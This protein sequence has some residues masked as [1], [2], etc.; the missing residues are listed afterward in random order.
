MQKKTQ[1]GLYLITPPSLKIEKFAASFEQALLADE[2]KIIAALQ[3]RLK[4]YTQAQLIS[5]ANALRPICV[6]HKIM[7]LM[8]DFPELASKTKCNGVHIGQ[9]DASLEVARASV[10]TSQIIGVTCHNSLKLARAASEKGADYVAFGAFFPTKTKA[11]NFLAQKHLLHEWAS[12][13]DIPSVAIGGITPENCHSLVRAGANF[14][15]VISSFWGHPN[16]P[17]AA[18]IA[19]KN[20]ITAA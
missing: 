18:V 5:I 1:C 13:S 7:L 10:G 4:E 8:N 16:G 9:T 2:T 17:D 11:V 6:K 19:F 15:A 14:L 12:T 3:I 20:A